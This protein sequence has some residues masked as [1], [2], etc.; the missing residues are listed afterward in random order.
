MSSMAAPPRRTS[1]GPYRTTSDGPHRLAEG[2]RSVS[3]GPRR[4]SD[5]PPRRVSDGPQSPIGGRRRSSVFDNARR[6]FAVPRTSLAAPAR[7]YAQIVPD[8][9]P[10]LDYS[11]WQRKRSIGIFWGLILFDSIVMP[12]ALYFGLWYGLTRDQLSANAVFSI[13]TA[14]LGGISIFEY[15]VRFLRLFKKGSKCRVIG[16]RRSYVSRRQDR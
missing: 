9:P 8:R 7:E 15:A 16:G 14:A 5:R 3:D 13:V 2:Q 4:M 11:L 6:S 10:P 1:D 12:L